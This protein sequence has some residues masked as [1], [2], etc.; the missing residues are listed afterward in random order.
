M[1]ERFATTPFGGGR[2]RAADF[3]RRET[4][5]RQRSALKEGGND[6]GRAEKWQLLRALSEARSV[7]GL[8][9]RAIA[10]LEALMSFH[11]SRELDGSA[12]IIVF[13]SNAELSLRCRGMAD[14]TLRRHIAA[15]VEAG[16][17]LRRDSPN[18]KRYCRRDDHGGVESAFGFDLSPLALA[19]AG[20]H[21]AAEELR[22]YARLCQRVRG[23]ITIHLRDTGKIIEAG[24]AEKRAGDWQGFMLALVPLSR[25]MARQASLDL[26]ET[27]RDD[28]IRLRAQVETAYLDGLDEQ[29]MSANDVDSERHYQNSKTEPHFET[30]SEKELKRGGDQSDRYGR[31]TGTGDD[32]GGEGLEIG[33]APETKGEP[34]PLSYLL[35]V[36]PTLATYAKDGI[37]GWREVLKTA[38][39]VRSM[40]GISPDAWQRARTAMG[41]INAAITVA[42]ILERAEMIRSPGGYLRA[43]TE[44]AELGQ[45]SPKPMLAA[46]EKSEGA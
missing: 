27:R 39:L 13:P 45:F 5:E 6:T 14:A 17:I 1:T 32:A 2:V 38:D 41:E 22:A 30:S 18:G 43:L 11:Q 35:G 42:A 21:T 20:I 10:V 4:V 29:E 33:R 26:L 3:Q 31:P 15:L 7:Y 28:L 25:R 16:L 24:L 40:L 8:S 37:A 23:E 9:D 44:R 36:C 19:A 46:L 34:V 12:P